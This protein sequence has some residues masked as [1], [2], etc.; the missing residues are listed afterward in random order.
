[1]THNSVERPK[2]VTD[3]VKRYP[4]LL[5]R[6]AKA[7]R[8]ASVSEAAVILRDAIARRKNYSEWVLTEHRADAMQAIHH[9]VR[10]TF[11][12]DRSSS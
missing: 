11:R 8:L 1:M 3:F 9:V 2:S 10:G 7:G 4:R 12:R 5:A 6:I